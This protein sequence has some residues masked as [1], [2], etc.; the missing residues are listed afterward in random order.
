MNWAGRHVLHMSVLVRTV[1]KVGTQ[2][3]CVQN[4]DT[5]LSAIHYEFKY[6]HVI[7]VCDVIM[8]SH[9]LLS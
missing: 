3:T 7:F 4:N 2:L 6:E 5:G 8:A 1:D 9:S